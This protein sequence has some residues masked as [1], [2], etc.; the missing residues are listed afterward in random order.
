MPQLKVKYRAPK[1][2]KQ[3]WADKPSKKNEMPEL[4]NVTMPVTKKELVDWYGRKC[5]DFHPDC[6][7]CVA[8]RMWEEKGEMTVTV[9]R[10]LFVH[11]FNTGQL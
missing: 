8:W 3:V 10:A 9:D 11:A 5:D 4:L 6:A 2:S 1:T 7:G